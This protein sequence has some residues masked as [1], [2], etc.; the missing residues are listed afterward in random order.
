M[1]LLFASLPLFSFIMPAPGVDAA[2]MPNP[3]ENNVASFP[4]EK[5]AINEK[6]PFGTDVEIMKDVSL[7]LEK[8]INAGSTEDLKDDDNEDHIIITGADAARYLLPMR[9][10]G[11]P[12][13]SRL[14]LYHFDCP[15]EQR[16]R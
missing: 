6:L 3:V 7:V 9:D 1:V 11:E 15:S 5:L 2:A 8:E 14:S 4:D 10:D 16:R 12:S 13:L